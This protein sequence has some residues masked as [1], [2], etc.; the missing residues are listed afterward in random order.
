MADTMM[1]NVCTNN[2]HVN[3]REPK[4]SQPLAERYTW[5][6]VREFLPVPSWSAD[7]LMVESY[8]AAWETCFRH[9]HVP[10]EGCLISSAYFAHPCDRSL[11]V[12]NSC[13]MTAF[14]KY[15]LR[16]FAPQETIECFFRLQAA[17][18]R[19]PERFDRDGRET[20]SDET[21]FDSLSSLLTWSEWE[22][23][24]FTGD[25]SRF[26]STFLPLVRYHRWFRSSLDGAMR[27][28]HSVRASCSFGGA[29]T[30]TNTVP[31]G[32]TF[33]A[34]V[35]ALPQFI[36]LTKVLLRLVEELRETEDGVGA[37][38]ERPES[39]FPHGMFPGE[40]ESLTQDLVWAAYLRK[41]FVSLFGKSGDDFSGGHGVLSDSRGFANLS[42]ARLAG[43]KSSRDSDTSSIRSLVLAGDEFSRFR[44]AHAQGNHDRV[45]A[46]AYSRVKQIARVYQANR[47]FWQY[48]AADPSETN[49]A[50]CSDFVGSTGT[51]AISAFL[52]N[53]LGLVRTV[54]GSD[55]IWNIFLTDEFSVANYPVG[56]GGVASFHCARRNRSTDTP[57]VTVTCNVPLV[58]DVRWGGGGQ[59]I[60]GVGR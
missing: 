32:G 33:V 39:R 45:F 52:E 42:E 21:P 17:D 5:Q 53:V 4:G 40:W 28:G 18:G 22:Y 10:Y 43:A 2:L 59:R 7:E 23:Y 44:T 26:R 20:D 8:W 34:A 37:D 36:M 25:I 47:S 15:A 46:D 14:L 31:G 35:R 38:S 13:L 41:R 11:S 50:G 30:S 24:S 1:S 56:H 27:R 49:T 3:E 9:V 55:I 48:Y 54:H 51:L 12:V 6:T 19:I 16:A 60:M 57:E 58:V 29:P